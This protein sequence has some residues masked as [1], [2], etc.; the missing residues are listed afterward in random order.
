MT[1]LIFDADDTLWESVDHFRATEDAFLDILAEQG[2]DRAR[3]RERVMQ[4]DRERAP[5]QGYGAGAFAKTLL[6]TADELLPGGSSYELRRRVRHLGSALR[7]HPIQLL[8]MVF[9]TL[10]DLRQRNRYRLVLLTKGHADEQAAKVERSDLGRIF[11]HCEVLR[12]KHPAAYRDIVSRFDCSPERT[13]MIGNSP[14]SD[15]NPALE[16]GLNA[17]YIPHPR[18]W[19]LEQAQLLESDRLTIVERFEDLLQLFP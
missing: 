4:R 2:I 16:A 5:K 10:S 17:V 3:A 8:P 18:T 11:N 7:R 15:I 13:W 1:T 14:R 6:A 19:E 12:E 9:E